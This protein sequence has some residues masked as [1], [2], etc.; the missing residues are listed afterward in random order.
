MNLKYNL[1]HPVKTKDA[2][3]SSLFRRAKDIISDKDILEK[4]N[5]RMVKVLCVSISRSVAKRKYT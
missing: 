2:V 4:E 1:N 3:V 5:E